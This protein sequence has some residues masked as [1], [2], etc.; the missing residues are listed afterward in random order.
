MTPSRIE[1][2]CKL[3]VHV[4]VLCHVES[5]VLVRTVQDNKIVLPGVFVMHS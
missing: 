3:C 5:R 1:P 4:I 2:A